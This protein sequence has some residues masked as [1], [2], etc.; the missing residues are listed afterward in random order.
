MGS[1]YR[2]ASLSP[3]ACRRFSL[4]MCPTI[5]SAVRWGQRTLCSAAVLR[6]GWGGASH[7]VF[8]VSSRLFQIKEAY[9]SCFSSHWSLMCNSVWSYIPQLLFRRGGFFRPEV[10]VCPLQSVLKASVFLIPSFQ[11]CLVLHISKKTHISG[12]TSASLK[13]LNLSMLC[14]VP[15]HP[16]LMNICAL[17]CF[18]HSVCSIPHGSCAPPQDSSVYIL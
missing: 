9:S 12:S 7:T 3:Q 14:P 1:S 18:V 5:V 4:W 6:G 10:S 13:Y 2:T 15:I 16:V 11:P 8:G 17:W